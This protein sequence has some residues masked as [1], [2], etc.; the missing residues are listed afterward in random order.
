MIYD[1][2]ELPAIVVTPKKELVILL[3]NGHA[4]NT[5]GK[6]SP[7]LPDGTRFYEYQFNRDIVKRIAKGLDALKIPYHILVPEEITDVA[8]TTR[9]NRANEYCR[10]YG[11]EN[12]FLISVHANAAGNGGWM[13]ARGW[14][15]YTTKGWTKSDEYA[16]YFYNEAKKL[17]PSKN[18]TL[19]ADWSD[20]DPDWEAN[21]TILYKTICSCILTENLFYD[22]KIDLA[23]L[24]SEEGKDVIAQIHINAIKE[25]YD[26]HR[27]LQG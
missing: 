10:K 14:S 2:G 19:R 20:G 18:M 16:T 24:M 4:K 12:C 13:N 7:V 9:A 5:P 3:D 26:K 17:L 6:C 11:K 21:F 15:V 23:F 1:G 27:S 25:I 8:L 22:N